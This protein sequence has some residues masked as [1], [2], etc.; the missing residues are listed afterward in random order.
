M[1]GEQTDEQK[2]AR[3]EAAGWTVDRYGPRGFGLAT[4]QNPELAGTPSKFFAP[5]DRL[6]TAW[7]LDDAWAEFVRRAWVAHDW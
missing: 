4:S 6:P 5:G 1:T 2:I 7:N 3:L